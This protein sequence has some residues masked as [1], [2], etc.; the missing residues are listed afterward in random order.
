VQI[1]YRCTNDE[2]VRMRI[3]RLDDP[4]AHDPRRR[5]RLGVISAEAIDRSA[6]EELAAGRRDW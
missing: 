1:V 6:M 5:C 3:Q 4:R 2:E